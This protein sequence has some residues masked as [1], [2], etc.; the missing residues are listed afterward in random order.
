MFF[1]NDSVNACFGPFNDTSFSLSLIPL[2]KFA[3]ASIVIF[4]S[5]IFKIQNPSYISFTISSYFVTSFKLADGI[6][7]YNV[8][9][10]SLV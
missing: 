1:P 8:L 4:L 5:S 7:L 9:N 2:S 10:R 3:L 6:E